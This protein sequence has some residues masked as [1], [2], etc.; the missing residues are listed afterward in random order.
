MVLALG[1]ARVLHGLHK[2]ALLCQGAT[3]AT[4]RQDDEGRK[5]DKNESSHSYYLPSDGPGSESR[6]LDFCHVFVGR[7][8][9]VGKAENH[10]TFR[11]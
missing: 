9:G 2:C 3:T 7:K 6:A 8:G 4:E 5:T 10:P 11:D 1:G